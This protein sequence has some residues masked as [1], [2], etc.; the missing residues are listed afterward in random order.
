MKKTYKKPEMMLY[1]VGIQQL[2]TASDPTKLEMI[3]D[4]DTQANS[5]TDVL[6][7][8]SSVWDDEEAGQEEEW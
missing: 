1:T 2:C 3:T 6:S 5:K 4:T 8:Q 7:R